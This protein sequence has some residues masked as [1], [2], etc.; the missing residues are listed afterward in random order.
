MEIVI[1]DPKSQRF[2]HTVLGYYINTMKTTFDF[3]FDFNQAVKL[4]EKLLIEKVS[5]LITTCKLVFRRKLVNNQ[6][7]NKKVVFIILI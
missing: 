1:Q 3:D 6:N 2:S 7:L 5:P 4:K